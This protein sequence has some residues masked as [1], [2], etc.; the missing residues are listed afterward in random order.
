[1]VDV[2]ISYKDGIIFIE[3][4]YLAPVEHLLTHIPFRLIIYVNIILQLRI[5]VR[6]ISQNGK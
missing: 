2:T 4:K 6:M 1:V 3:A 5:I